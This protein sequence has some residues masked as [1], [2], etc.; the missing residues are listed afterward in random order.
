MP[1]R[2]PCAAHLTFLL[3][4]LTHSALVLTVSV[5]PPSL[6]VLPAGAAATPRERVIYSFSNDCFNPIAP[7]IADE[8][9]NLYGT[10]F[11]GG[12]NMAGC[13]FELSPHPDGTWSEKALHTFN[14]ADGYQP[15]AAL[16]FDKSGNLYGTA[17]S[18]GTY[19]GGVVFKLS[20]SRDG[21]WTETALYNFGKGG[22]AA[23]LASELVFDKH[24]NLYGT[25][26][27][28]GSGNGGTV[29]KL[30]PSP[31]GWIQTILHVFPANNPYS[32]ST[33]DGCNPRGSIVFDSKG[34]M[35]GTTEG[36]GAYGFGA[37]YELAPAK[38]GS[39]QERLLH[40][41]SGADGSQPLS[42]LTMDSSGNLYGTTFDGGDLTAC[43]NGCGTVFKL[44]KH[45]DGKWTESVLYA[46]TASDG[47]HAGGSVVFDR[48]GNLYAA[49]AGG[50]TGIDGS[51]FR[52]T[53]GD[54]GAFVLHRFPWPS[55]GDGA[56]PYAGLT[57]R[58]RELF[59]T[60]LIGGAYN[61]G[62]VFTV[63]AVHENDQVSGI[64]R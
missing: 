14:V 45:G 9:G 16:I 27:F 60:T 37:V 12:P 52:L 18:G 24:G 1:F 57:L 19:G 51:V 62:T 64:S 47:N 34:R 17:A 21:E 61:S 28:G 39:Y 53:P 4:R 55:T 41:F 36:G 22:N 32:C 25:T 48:A 56:A 38:D 63:G 33:T 46:L 30:S 44:T 3:R 42:T 58:G 8:D 11:N 59:G 23:N 7:L 54:D 50:S 15:V 43:P 35:Y 2:A 26:E 31:A 10:A 29:Y 49:A 20:P 6:S 13:V 40:S 5:L